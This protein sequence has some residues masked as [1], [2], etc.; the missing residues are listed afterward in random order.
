MSKKNRYIQ[1]D[2]PY[3]TLCFFSDTNFEYKCAIENLQ[4]YCYY[5]DINSAERIKKNLHFYSY[6]KEAFFTVGYKTK[7]QV[8]LNNA[9]KI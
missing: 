1:T 9:E 3:K 5:D 6:N 8:I 7:K 2:T 4:Y